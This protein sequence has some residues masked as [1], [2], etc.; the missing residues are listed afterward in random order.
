MQISDGSLTLIEPEEDTIE[1]R[2]Q[3]NVVY[4]GL[5][6]KIK[7]CYFKVTGINTLG[8]KAVGISRREYFDN[9]NRR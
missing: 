7:H 4:A 6:F 3:S 2:L 8:L 1:K 9:R 5:Y